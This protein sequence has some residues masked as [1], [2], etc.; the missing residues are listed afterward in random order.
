LAG[1]GYRLLEGMRAEQ[2]NDESTIEERLLQ[3]VL[4]KDMS[5]PRDIIAIRERFL[6]KSPHDLLELLINTWC[7]DASEPRDRIFAFIG[8]LDEAEQTDSFIDYEKPVEHVY[9]D[10]T[11]MD[12]RRSG[13]LDALMLTSMS[14]P[15]SLALP[16][17]C[18]DWS[19]CSDDTRTERLWV[20]RHYRY[21]TWTAGGSVT[22]FLGNS[23]P[24]VLELSGIVV[25]TVKT[26]SSMG[27]YVAQIL[28]QIFSV[29]QQSGNVQEPLPLDIKQVLDEWDPHSQ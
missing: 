8:L 12:I 20:L 18:P 10:A 9:A 7:R 21:S 25:G 11:K 16:S 4:R 13:K 27:D 15:T 14:K 2:K 26:V 28:K 5:L 3:S 1:T 17:W 29:E 24:T 22:K 19:V 6:Q 23:D